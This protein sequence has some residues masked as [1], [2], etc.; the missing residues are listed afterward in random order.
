MTGTVRYPAARFLAAALITLAA[1]AVLAPAASAAPVDAK[2]KVIL[3]SADWDPAAGTFDLRGSLRSRSACRRK[4][5][6]FVFRGGTRVK[7]KSIANGDFLLEGVQ[8]PA[9]EAD[10]KVRVG[11]RRLTSN[12]Q[13]AINCQ[14]DDAALSYHWV[15]SGISLSYDSGLNAFQAAVGGSDSTC[16]DYGD[17]Q[18]SLFRDGEI[19]AGSAPVQLSG[20][21]ALALG[22]PAAPGSYD[23]YKAP[24]GPDGATH[25]RNGGMIAAA[26]AAIDSNEVLI[27]P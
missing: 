13:V 4:R 20:S 6:V 23:I 19:E 2:T 27:T 12:Q 26:C 22:S 10:Y 21:W 24:Y 11:Q 5:T 3:D 18:L 25:L 8:L 17:L 1:A 16:V 14:T 9:A 15:E 7:A